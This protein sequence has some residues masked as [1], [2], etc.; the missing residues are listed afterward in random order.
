[1]QKAY[2]TSQLFGI[3]AVPFIIAA[4][5]RTYKGAPENLAAWLDNKQERN[6]SEK[7]ETQKK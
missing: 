7:N 4:D 3:N 6:A 2:I 1:M 5:G